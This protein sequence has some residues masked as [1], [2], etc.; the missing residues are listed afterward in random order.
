MPETPLTPEQIG[1]MSFTLGEPSGQ[2]LQPVGLLVML[3]DYQV[4]GDV[5]DRVAHLA[6]ARLADLAR[7]EGHRDGA[8]R[9]T[10]W[11]ASIKLVPH[12]RDWFD[13]D[14]RSRWAVMATRRLA[15]M[16]PAQLDARN[17]V[18]FAEAPLVDSWRPWWQVQEKTVI[19][20]PI[21]PGTTYPGPEPSPAELEAELIAR[22]HIR[23]PILAE[24][25]ATPA[26]RRARVEVDFSRMA[27]LE[28]GL[29]PRSWLLARLVLTEGQSRLAIGEDTPLGVAL[30]PLARRLADEGLL[31]EL[32]DQGDALYHFER[33]RALRD[34]RLRAHLPPGPMYG[35]V[36]GPSYGP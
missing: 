17:L 4:S 8:C 30:L 27:Q 23:R 10:R 19:G 15:E 24:W 36:S 18:S 3:A 25:L 5:V 9:C 20:G 33:G 7:P 12:I 31:R 26:G 22:S 35:T 6:L 32:P 1:R 2:I 11:Q 28:L 21:G 14:E 34:P 13:P 29:D 16:A